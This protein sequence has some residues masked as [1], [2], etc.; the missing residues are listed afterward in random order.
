MDR[1]SNYS[2]VFIQI[3]ALSCSAFHRSLIIGTHH[4]VTINIISCDPFPFIKFKCYLSWLY[5][6]VTV[7]IWYGWASRMAF[8]VFFTESNCERLRLQRRTKRQVWLERD[9]ISSDQ[10]REESVST[11]VRT[12]RPK[13]IFK[14]F[15]NATLKEARLESAWRYRVFEWDWV[16]CLM[17]GLS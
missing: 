9:F 4:V 12:G 15:Q 5:V 11:Y 16:S 7:F 6:I 14:S 8:P 1:W 13:K 10:H 3:Y 17:I 2:I